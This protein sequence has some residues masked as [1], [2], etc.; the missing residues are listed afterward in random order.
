MQF[1]KFTI[2]VLDNFSV[3]H[4]SLIFKKDWIS[5]ISGNSPFAQDDNVF[6]FYKLPENENVFDF[7]I[8]IADLRVFLKLIKEFSKCSEWDLE[9]QENNFLLTST[10]G[11]IKYYYSNNEIMLDCPHNDMITSLPESKVRFIL[12]QNDLKQVIKFSSILGVS[13]FFVVAGK[14]KV[15]ARVTNLKDPTSNTYTIKLGDNQINDSENN[16]EERIKVAFLLSDLNFF[17]GDY[18]VDIAPNQ[19][20]KFTHIEYPD[21]VYI[22]SMQQLEEN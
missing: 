3:I 5:T 22:I 2:A 18:I 6:A 11:K 19:S 17:D 10:L 14:G 16:S 15:A 12:K 9:I 4:P 21:L 13:D 1:S 7:P 8:G 20:A